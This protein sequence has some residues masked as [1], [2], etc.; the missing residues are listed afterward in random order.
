MTADREID[1]E[2]EFA[3]SRLNRAVANKLWGFLRP[4]TRPLLWAIVLEFGWVACLLA[5][6]HLIKVALDDMI[7]AG[8]V[9]GLALIGAVMVGVV[10]VRSGIAILQIQLTMRAGIHFLDDLRQA[11]FRHIQA[12]SMRYFDRTR[13]GRII[14]RVD[15]DIESLEHPVVWGPLIFTSLGLTLVGVLFMMLSYDWVLGLGMAALVP[16]LVLVSRFFRDRG[17]EAYRHVRESFTR[18]TAHYA[19]TI[20]GVR[21]IQAFVGEDR[22]QGRFDDL[23]DSHNQKIMKA[24][25]IWNGY[26]PSMGALYAIATVA[27]IFAGGHRLAA[28]FVTPGELAAFFLLLGMFFRPIEGLGDLYN[29]A[30]SATSSAERI[31]LLLDTPPEVV[32]DEAAVEVSQVEGEVRFEDVSFSYDTEAAGRG[33]WHIDGLDLHIPAGTSAAFVGRTGAGKSSIINL[34]ARFYDVTGGRVLLDGRD[35]RDIKLRS[36]HSHMGIVLQESFLF[37]GTVME[38]IKFARPEATDAEAIEAARRL[39]CEEVFE[40]LADGFQTKV[41][42]RGGNLSEG[43]RQ[44]V[45][46]TRAMLADPSI[47]I[48]DEATSSVDVR[49]EQRIQRALER[50]ARDRTTLIV[51]HRLATIRRVDCIFVM[52]AGRIV[53]RGTHDELVA[54]NGIYADMVREYSVLPAAG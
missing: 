8:N 4:H 10:F 22:N 43:E 36:L 31:F 23:L 50:L 51:A 7:P 37:Q 45:S 2:E 18:I 27:L 52:D 49:T 30:L 25:I 47:L 48:L 19:E 20:G 34:V 29:Q 11:L 35:V 42:D 33:G 26:L 39:G 28:G 44:L 13:H 38:N 41:G 14:A 16:A 17:L 54:E 40:R 9:A 21:V 5:V 12:L 24:A 1:L 15:R 32:D 46:F 3:Q 6:P 53:E